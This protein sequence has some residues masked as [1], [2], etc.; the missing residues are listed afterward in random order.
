MLEQVELALE[1]DPA[2]EYQ[3]GQQDELNESREV[4]L[5]VQMPGFVRVGHKK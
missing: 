1:I 4:D 3:A 5:S 2:C